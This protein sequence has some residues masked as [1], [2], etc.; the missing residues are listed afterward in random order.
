[1]TDYTKIVE[2]IIALLVAI[3]TTFVIPYIKSKIDDA[4]MAKII[5]WVTYAVKAAEQIY[6]ES[7]MGAI[8]NKYVKKFLEEH[9]VDLDIEQID[10]LI[11][12]AVWE[13]TNKKEDEA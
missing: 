8:K 3:I 11:E 2:T 9:G 5:E 7:G 4:K 10:V 12:S 13:L 1:M 6:K